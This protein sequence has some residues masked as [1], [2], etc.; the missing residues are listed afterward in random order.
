MPASLIIGGT[1]GIGRATALLLA[2]RGHRVAVTGRNPDSLAAVRRELP[3]DALVLSSDA[4]SLAQTEATLDAVRDG[5]GSLDALFLNAGNSRPAPIEAVT[6]EAFDDQIALNFKGLYFTLQKALPLLN[7]G[8]SVILTVGAGVSRGI[9][10]GSLTSAARGA[11]LAMMPSLVLE[12][13]PRSIRINAVSPGAID[14]PIWSGLGASEQMRAAL[15]AQI[16]FGR[17][18]TPDEVAETVAFLASDASAYI[19]GQEIT[20]AGGW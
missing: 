20:V 7:D 15:T 4:R 2:R 17:F 14:T 10:G 19:T 6:E 5:F 8:A 18:G 16:P 9:S 12:L 1:S 11:L 13:A 3:D